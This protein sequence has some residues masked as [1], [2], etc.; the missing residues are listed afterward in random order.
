MRDR[1]KYQ[2]MLSGAIGLGAT[3]RPFIAA[4]MLH[5]SGDGWTWIF[6][7]PPILA[8]TCIALIVLF[9]PL[10]P[11]VGSLKEKIGKIDWYRLTVAVN[12]DVVP[13]GECE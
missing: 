11:V 8:A 13:I 2:G 3:T 6:W 9:L 5:K 12:W 4:S 7:I 10:K 1:G